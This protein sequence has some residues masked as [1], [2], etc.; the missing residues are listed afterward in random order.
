MPFSGFA[1]TAADP[2]KGV[3]RGIFCEGVAIIDIFSESARAVFI[4]HGTECVFFTVSYTVFSGCD[5]L[6]MPEA[7]SRDSGASPGRSKELKSMQVS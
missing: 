7:R 6:A 5:G 3:V 4:K 1:C 2:N